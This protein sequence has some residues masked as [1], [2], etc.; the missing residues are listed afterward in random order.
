MSRIEFL[1]IFEKKRRDKKQIKRKKDIFFDFLKLTVFSVRPGAGIVVRF[2]DSID[3]KNNVY[4]IIIEWTMMVG[5]NYW[6]F[7]TK[8][9][10]NTTTFLRLCKKCWEWWCCDDGGL[11]SGLILSISLLIRSAFSFLTTKGPGQFSST[12]RTHW[13]WTFSEQSINRNYYRY[14]EEN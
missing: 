8:I 3:W 10:R 13:R 5:K 4:L 7:I 14:L 12:M 2:F 11:R 1:R 6:N 9:K